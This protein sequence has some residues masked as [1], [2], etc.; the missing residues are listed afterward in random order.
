[1]SVEKLNEALDRAERH[2]PHLRLL[3]QRH[4]DVRDQLAQGNLAAALDAHQRSKD[5]DMP[6]GVA[7]RQAKGELAL[8]VAIGD[9]AGLLSLE[10]VTGLLSDFAD[11]ALDRAMRAALSEYRPGAEFA[12]MTAIA[13][14]KHG[15]RELNYSSDIDP[16]LLFD[17]ASLPRRERD[18]PVDA[19]V[20][21]GRRV[22]EL[23]QARTEHGY[24]FRIDLRLRPTPEVTP[25]VMPV[26]AAISYYESQA[27]AWERA[28]FIRSRACAGDAAL[29]QYFTQA[30]R[31]FVWRRGLDFGAIREIR[32]ISHRIRDHYS[33]GQAFGPGFD[34]KRGRG[35]IRECEFFAQIHQLIHGGRDPALRVPATV[36]ALM[37]LADAGHIDRDEAE[38]LAGAYRLY[39]TIEHRLQMVDDQQTHSLPRQADALLNVAQLDGLKDA[40][41]LLNLLR[42]HLQ[43]V[44]HLYDGLDGPAQTALPQQEDGLAAALRAA[45]FADPGP[46]LQRIIHWRSGAVRAVRTPAAHEALEAVLPK[47][48]SGLGQAPDPLTAINQFSTI[49]ERLPSAINLFRLLEARPT[50]LAMLADILCHAPALAE[51]LGQRPAMLDRL[52]DAS[53]FDAP[54]SVAEIAALLAGGETLEDRLDHVRHLVGEMRFALG[55]QL[56]GGSRDALAVAKGYARI[57]EAAIQSVAEATIAAFE[58]VHGKVPGGELIILALGRM[59]GAE[60]THA[61]DLDLIYL[62]TGDFSVE[63]D[64]A[65]PLG[66]VHYF[67]RLSQRVTNGLSVATAAGPLYEVDTRLRPSGNDGPLAVSLEA[68]A[69][70]QAENAWTWE[71]M[72]LTRARPVFGS[73]AAR[74]A[75]QKTINTVLRRPR[76][77]RQLIADA[78]K[79]RADMAT[80]KPPQ[81]PLDVKLC[82]GGL[83]D[84]EFLTH[85]SQLASG[86]GLTPDL[87]D[88]IA[89][90]AKAGLISDEMIGAHW[91]LTRTLVA[92]RLMAPSLAI[93]PEVTRPVIARASGA[94]NWDDLLAQLARTR[95]SVAREWG[96]ISTTGDK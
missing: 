80:H 59:G 82:A 21:I 83:V 69:R 93:P 29:G 90:L 38:T 64:G 42:P 77:T 31:P 70:Y 75:T 16:I 66:A 17:P 89:A 63:S 25:I 30:L 61:S 45:G 10:D 92:V 2:A 15:S 94:D 12:G 20:R 36:P 84:L 65:K 47:L 19:A 35:G 40:D 24:V 44:S 91:L 72:A 54:G 62:F 34:L 67:N 73:A 4:G 86:T 39:R 87:G 51:Q 6:V 32:G 79:M 58:A 41:A 57:A 1:M 7:L 60:L 48:V 37:A 88:A 78:A 52:I 8:A 33:Q 46:A 22:V 27:V 9:L 71:H 11:A 49:V 26:E 14:G 56:V 81:G 53:A 28:A 50:L 74:E 23:M 3:M 96:R 55:V 5:P 85:V 68:F 95:Q 43:S 13:L 18:D 76:D